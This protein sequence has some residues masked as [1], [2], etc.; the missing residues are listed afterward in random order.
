MSQSQSDYI[1]QKKSIYQL[2]YGETPSSNLSS[3][4]GIA[5]QYYDTNNYDLVYHEDYSYN[6]WDPNTTYN[7]YLPY[8]SYKY[9]S[10]SYVPSYEDSIYLS[11]SHGFKRKP[12]TLNV[13]IPIGSVSRWYESIS[14]YDMENPSTT[15]QELNTKP[16]FRQD[17]CETPALS[18]QEKDDICKNMDHD[19]CMETNCCVSIGKSKCVYGGEFGPSIPSTYNDTSLNNTDYYYYRSKCYGN[20]PV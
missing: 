10:K 19:S 8:H 5:F 7:T 6:A 13:E 20:C 14:V 9:G 17:F 2:L 1:Q 11:R 15:N 12:N 4:A 18:I 16:Q 3:T